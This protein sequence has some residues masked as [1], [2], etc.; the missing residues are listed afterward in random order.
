[1]HDAVKRNNF[2]HSNATCDNI[3]TEYHELGWGGIKAVADYRAY[4]TSDVL[5]LLY[6]VAPKMI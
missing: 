6:I 2:A 4:T 3:W 5:D 1:M